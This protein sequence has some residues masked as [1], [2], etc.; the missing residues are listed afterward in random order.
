MK[1]VNFLADDD[2]G[3]ARL[4]YAYAVIPVVISEAVDA[5]NKVSTLTI[6]VISK[7]GRREQQG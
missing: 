5:I 1:I 7:D 4:Q 2:T 6:D 3:I